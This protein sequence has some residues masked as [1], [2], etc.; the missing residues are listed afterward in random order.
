EIGVARTEYE[1]RR[2]HTAVL[3]SPER[4]IQEAQRLGME[5]PADPPTYLTVPGAP[6]AP[7]DAGDTATTLGDWKKVKPEL[8]DV[9]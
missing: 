1:Q 2:L 6:A 9:P 7:S 8:G 3:A 5:M 4:I